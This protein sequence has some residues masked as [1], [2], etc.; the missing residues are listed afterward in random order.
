MRALYHPIT[1]ETACWTGSWADTDPTQPP[2]HAAATVNGEDHAYAFDHL[3]PFHSWGEPARLAWLD[4]IGRDAL[5]AKR[6]A[7]ASL[8]LLPEM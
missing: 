2:F 8:R 3:L 4:L 1:F 5:D 6:S 7:R